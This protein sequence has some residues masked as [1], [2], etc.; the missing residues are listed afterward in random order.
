MKRF[1]AIAL[2]AC[3][4]L[5]LCERATE[6]GAK[7][8]GEVSIWQVTPTFTDV[9]GAVGSARA[10]ADF[11]QYIGCYTNWAPGQTPW[12]YCSA[13]DSAGNYRS[14]YWTGSDFATAISGIGPLSYIDFGFGSDNRCSN[15][16]IYNYSYDPPPVP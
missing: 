6:A 13:V 11:N 2:V 12:G 3:S 14:C 10:S 4:A 5:V 16:T 7:Y 1:I 8:G 15:L 9:R